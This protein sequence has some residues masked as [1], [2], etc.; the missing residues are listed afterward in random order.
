[1]D[2][3]QISRQYLPP[4]VLSSAKAVRA[5]AELAQF[6][7]W[8]FLQ[9]EKS[10]IERPIFM[11]GCPRS[12]TTVS[13][14]IFAKHPDV[15]NKSEAGR[16]WDPQGYYDPKADHQWTADEVTEENAERLHAYFEFIRRR[17]GK[18]R[19]INKH[20]RSSVRIEFLEKIFPDALYI[21]AIRDGRAVAHSI[22]SRIGREEWRHP[23]PFGNFCKPPE[24]ERFRR[25]DPIE[26][27]ALQW[28]EIT[29][30]ILDRKESLGERY[31]EFTYEGLCENPRDTMSELFNFCG[32]SANAAVLDAIPEKLQNFNSKYKDDLTE[33]QI[34]TMENVQRELLEQLGYAVS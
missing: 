12:G 9:S 20:P 24:W 15:V 19:L 33:E 30:Y 5:Q 6:N 34:A 25:E 29:Q 27:A 1:M 10:T 16:I 31:I 28:R 3:R 8:S 21:H 14:G 4:T 22:A 32:L 7:V 18:A 17:S 26:Q 23:I 11:I 2:L 13:V